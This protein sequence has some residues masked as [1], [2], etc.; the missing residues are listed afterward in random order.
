[1]RNVSKERATGNMEKVKV[2]QQV[3][4][5]NGG[6]GVSAEYR[7]LIQSELSQKYEF[8][9]IVLNGS[10]PGVNLHDIK[11]YYTELKKTEPDIVHIRGAAVD[12]LTAI[13]AAKLRGKGRILVTVH[14][15][16]SDMV[17]IN[18]VKKFVAK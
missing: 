11:Y 14:G 10:K 12:G 6:G 16:Y 1:M 3:L 15:M 4:N 5:P 8:I 9:P 17:Y 18:P 13:I 2:A 7:A